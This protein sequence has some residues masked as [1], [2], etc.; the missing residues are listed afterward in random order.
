MELALELL[1]NLLLTFLGFVLPIVAIL[2]SIF[3]K[4]ISLL[5]EQYEN[6]KKQAEENIR[7]VSKKK[8][9]EDEIQSNLNELKDIKKQA[10]R[11]LSFLNPQKQIVRFFVPLILAF[12]GVELACFVIGK[13]ITFFK[14]KLSLSQM[15]FFLSVLLF[16]YALYVLWTLLDIIIEVKKAV[17]ESKSEDD[18]EFRKMLV[19]ISRSTKE[20]DK[21]FLKKVYITV[22]GKRILKGKP[23]ITLTEQ[24]KKELEIGIENIERRMA[25]QVEI[26]F[27]LPLDFMVEK[28]GS[29]NIYSGESRQ[30][31]RY[32]TD[33]LHGNKHLIFK[34]LA[35][36]PL[37]KGTYKIKA[38][39][40]AEN[41]ETTERK[42]T[43]K[44]V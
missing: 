29:Y 13:Y 39:I 38:F 20:R 41:I 19:S 8:I 28:S 12:S 15:L 17:D 40:G 36:T 14:F 7:I 30:I 5:S 1:G 2:L 33:I 21:Y 35:I 27:I 32:K 43:F 31:I 18:R 6:K 44:V 37:K 22:D 3:Q 9:D 24:E 26:G 16:A 10:G 34:S 4:G 42:F 25:K 23:I 11:R